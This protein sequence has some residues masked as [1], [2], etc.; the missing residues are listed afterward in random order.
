MPYIGRVSKAERK[1]RDREMV[2]NLIPARLWVDE[3]EI[4][5]KAETVG[6]PPDDVRGYLKRLKNDERLAWTRLP[7][8]YDR[9]YAKYPPPP[10]PE[11]P[12]IPQVPATV[13]EQRYPVTQAEI[14]RPGVK[15]EPSSKEQ[16][17]IHGPD[18]FMPR[19]RNMPPHET[20]EFIER[21]KQ[22][23][24]KLWL[25]R[26]QGFKSKIKLIEGRRWL[27]VWKWNKLE[28]KPDEPYIGEL[29]MATELA[30]YEVFFSGERSP[31]QE[32]RKK[33]LERQRKIRKELEFKYS[34]DEED[35]L[36]GRMEQLIGSG[37]YTIDEIAE[38]TKR[39]KADLLRLLD[40]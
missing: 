28:K 7:P 40:S 5:K 29:D 6:L 3:K 38:A 22:M 35:L 24:E 26:D 32:R 27:Y 37:K 4:I 12:E 19:L 1:M 11:P 10:I 16:K 34:R 30:A 31:A 39:E 36:K 18:Y 2:Y 20:A 9:Y 17:T 15:K 13:P 21:K 25:Y 8:S 33:E 23:K 14:Q